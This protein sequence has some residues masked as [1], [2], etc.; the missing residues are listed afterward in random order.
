MIGE[1]R[2][3]SFFGLKKANEDPSI[4]IKALMEVSGVKGPVSI[5]H[6]VYMIAPRV[7]AAGRMDDA[8]K[9]YTFLQKKTCQRP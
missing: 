4:A 3:I 8:R 2:I 5:Q 9:L 7:N 1:N 6:L